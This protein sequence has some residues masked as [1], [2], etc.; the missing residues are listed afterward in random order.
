MQHCGRC[1]S[2]RRGAFCWK[3]G[4]P[5][6]EPDTKWR[7]PRLPSVRAVRDLARKVGYAIGEHGSRERDLDLIAAPWTED[8]VTPDELIKHLCTGLN[9]VEVGGREEKPHGRIAV[10]LCPAGWFKMIDLSICPKTT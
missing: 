4:N 7:S 10:N 6:F 1:N 5:T 9:A 3:C 2:R 8:A